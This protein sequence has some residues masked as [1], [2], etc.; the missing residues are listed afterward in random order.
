MEGNKPDLNPQ[1]QPVKRKRDVGYAIVMTLLVLLFLAFSIIAFV[2]WQAQREDRPVRFLD[3]Y[4]Y[5]QRNDIMEP[6]IL[7]ND[8]LVFEPID[9]AL[10]QQTL[11]G[12]SDQIIMVNSDETAADASA[13]TALVSQAE[14]TPILQA[15]DVVLYRIR[16]TRS[17]SISR[18]VEQRSNDIWVVRG[19]RNQPNDAMQI[20]TPQIYGR[21]TNVL[22]ALGGPMLL[23]LMPVVYWGILA[24]L[25]MAIVAMVFI[26][27]GKS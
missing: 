23:I 19:D 17:F 16:G 25:A 9:E 15:D 24:A 1:E 10:A 4:M 26:H 12:V 27:R 7:P 22:P 3:N 6:S 13:D 14:T 2:L 11:A 18:V 21:L 8:M 20:E 5:I